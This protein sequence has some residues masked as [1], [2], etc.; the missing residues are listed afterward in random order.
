MILVSS[1]LKRY[2]KIIFF[3]FASNNLSLIGE[4]PIHISRDDIR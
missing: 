4:H 1:P 2:T 3:Y